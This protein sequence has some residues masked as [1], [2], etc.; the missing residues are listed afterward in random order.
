MSANSPQQRIE[1]FKDWYKWFNK[2][3]NRYNKLRFKK[4]VKK[5][6]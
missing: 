2:K 4:P 1:Q 5:Y 6:N 3:H